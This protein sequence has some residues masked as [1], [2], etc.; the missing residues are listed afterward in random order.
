MCKQGEWIR[1]TLLMKVKNKIPQ[2]RKKG[3]VYGIPCCDCDHVYVG[4]TGRTL[5]VRIAE[6]K[7]AVRRFDRKNGIAVHVHDQQHHMNYGFRNIVLEEKN[8]GSH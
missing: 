7:Q 4:E 8:H 3:V 5:K 1:D 6:H 2:D